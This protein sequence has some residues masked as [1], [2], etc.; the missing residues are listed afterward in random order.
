M[1]EL[2]VIR[3]VDENRYFI[4]ENKGSRQWSS[5]IKDATTYTSYSEVSERLSTD[6]DIP[7]GMY[8]IEKFFKK[9]EVDYSQE[10]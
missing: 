8:Q 3:S 10:D 2:F 1:E 4:Q 5:D 9:P 6:D 7:E